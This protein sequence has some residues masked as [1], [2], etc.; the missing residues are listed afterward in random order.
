MLRFT[1]SPLTSSHLRRSRAQSK[2][3]AALVDPADICRRLLGSNKSG[4][5]R[6]RCICPNSADA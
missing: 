6:V 1:T 5:Y 4:R 2:P 3:N